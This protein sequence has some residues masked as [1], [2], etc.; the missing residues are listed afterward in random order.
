MLVFFEVNHQCVFVIF[1][2]T[3]KLSTNPRSTTGLNKMIKEK[4]NDSQREKLIT[5]TVSDKH[6]K[7]HAVI[8]LATELTRVSVNLF[9]GQ[10]NRAGW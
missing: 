8:M 1:C 4:Q 5:G 2:L 9:I 7:L 10:Q 3:L 6:K